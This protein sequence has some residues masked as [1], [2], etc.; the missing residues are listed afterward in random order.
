MTA[1]DRLHPGVAHHIVNTLGWRTLRP[2]QEAAIEPVLAGDDALL[3][4]P[5]AG[6][7]TE[8][9]VFP[10]LTAMAEGAWTGISVLYLC[11]LRALLN[12]LHPRI[13]GYASWLGCTAGLW[14][15]DTSATQR[16]RLRLERP[17][18]LLTTPESLEAMLVSTLTD[19]RQ[20][21]A[22]LR[23][24]IVD[25]VH[26]FAGDDRGWHLLAVLERLSRIAGRRVQ[27]IGLS[28]TVGNPGDLLHWLQG[29][30]AA[31]RPGTVVA[32]SAPPGPTPAIDVTLDYVGGVDNA[33]TVIAALHRGEKR[34]AFCDSRAQVEQLAL[35]LRAKGVRTFV[36][37]SSLAA[38][39]RRQ[40]EQAFAEARDCV[41]VATATLELGV[42]VGD[43]DR[44]IQLDAPRTVAS[45]LQRLGRTGRRPGTDRNTLF[46]ATKHD[47]LL[48]AAGLLNLWLDGYVEPVV[49]PPRPRHIAAQ[50]ILALCLQE[51][52]IGGGTWPSWYGDLAIFD[53]TTPAI[54][55][56]LVQS[57][58]LDRDTGML[59]IGPQ[60]ERRYGRRHF[61]E[62]LTVFAAAPEF[63]VLHGRREVGSTDA[64]V[65]TM[66]V[67]GPRVIVLGGRAWKVTHI[68]WNRQR[69]YVEPTDL[70][71]R[72]L[73]HGFLPP[74]SW[75]L[76]QAQRRVLL[77]ADPD[78]TWSNRSVQ[79]LAAVRRE[80]AD[81]AWAGGS[82][83]EARED[84][85]RWWTW[86][87]RRANATI[88][89]ALPKAVVD[90]ARLDDHM[91]RL[92][93]DLTA[94]EL[95]H[96]VDA[97]DVER[98]AAPDIDER[99]V[100]GLKFGDV[101]PPHLAVATLAERAADPVG[102]AEILSAPLR[103]VNSP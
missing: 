57:G 42:D 2:L 20:V 18:I 5:T 101:L 55:E 45:F 86:A 83:V 70:P 11:P 46:L 56:W 33:A 89:A 60:T 25:E 71:G 69:C 91:V 47:T 103:W 78:V 10:A 73:W 31:H 13:A 40:A 6:G 30:N 52:R 3:L 92:R 16:R 61:M 37:H 9:A 74:E 94:G 1:V 38:D 32:P 28:A 68:D 80:R 24:V 51:H 87:G 65:L 62:L 75:S 43:L 21:F 17:D 72:S 54:V 49:P 63:T 76:A 53:Q 15:G 95:R 39:E 8:A 98:L 23:M 35:A 90:G 97:V 82:V 96:L 67:D 48:K 102:A 29:T 12:N 26:A 100:A 93:R 14:H 66:K 58:H 44:V 41:I 50:Q 4:A 36:S 99:A 34:L 19:P 27:R 81:H 88:A 79:A 59:A 85:H 77:G 7:K 84:E 64:I 22:D